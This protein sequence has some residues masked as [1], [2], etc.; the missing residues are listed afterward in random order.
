LF[1]SYHKVEALGTVVPP[2]AHPVDPP[3]RY[4][5][6][7]NVGVA[8]GKTDGAFVQL[9]DPPF[10]LRTVGSNGVPPPVPTAHPS[11][12]LT[13]K[14]ESSCRVF[15]EVVVLQ[16]ESDTVPQFAKQKVATPDLPTAQTFPPE[17]A[18]VTESRPEVVVVVPEDAI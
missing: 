8:S 5:P 2:T 16:I 10:H 6:R 1:P 4:T 18:K 13:M 7:K 14:T 3:E 11:E 17:V 15:G 12:S 9:M